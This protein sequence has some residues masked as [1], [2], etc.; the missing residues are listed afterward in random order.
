MNVGTKN[1]ITDEAQIGIPVPY[2][3]QADPVPNIL[4]LLLLLQ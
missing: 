1:Y 3:G 4:F 2:C